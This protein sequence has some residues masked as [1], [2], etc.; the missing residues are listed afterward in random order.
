MINF[1]E[2][3]N[4]PETPES[5]RGR[6]YLKADKN[7]YIK[8]DTGAVTQV[9][10]GAT[11][12]DK[13][14]AGAQSVVSAVDFNN[15]IKVVDGYNGVGTPQIFLAS[16]ESSSIED[17]GTSLEVKKTLASGNGRLAIDDIGNFPSTLIEAE[18]SNYNVHSQ[19]Q[20][21]TVPSSNLAFN[22]IS[23][24]NSTTG[25]AT[26]SILVKS[27][28][29]SEPT[30]MNLTLTNT[31]GGGVDAFNFIG[32]P[33]NIEAASEAPT[34]TLGV[35]GSNEVVQFDNVDVN[36]DLSV[37]Q[38]IVKGGGGEVKLG[39]HYLS[40]ASSG[41][42]SGGILSVSG[43]VDANVNIATT[44][45]FVIDTATFGIDT[46]VTTP[47]SVTSPIVFTPTNIATQNV[48]YVG[49]NSSG[50]QVEWNTLPTPEQRRDNIFLGVAVHS[51]RTTVEFVNNLQDVSSD[52]T[53]QLHDLSRYLGYFNI[54]GNGV[55]AN[56]ANLNFNKALGTAFKTG[57]NFAV[58]PKDPDT[59]YLPAKVASSFR[60]RT[61]TGGEGST[62]TLIDPT[63]YDVGGT[64]TAIAGSNNQSTIQ[65]IYV[66][67]SNE[68]RI[69]YGQTLYS[70]FSDAI[71]AVG[72]EPFV[73]ESNI[74]ENGLLL[75][76]LVVK[77]GATDLSDT[78]DA[79][80][81]QAG[82][83]GE[84]GS[85][86][87]TAVGTL[88]SG[89]D[90]SI[91]PEILTNATL[92]AVTLKRGS[93]LDTDDVLEVQNGAGTQTFKVT[94][95]GDAVVTGQVL[96]GTVT[97]TG[98]GVICKTFKSEGDA[99]V[100]DNTTNGRIFAQCSSTSYSDLV[101]SNGTTADDTR[102]IKFSS[103]YLGGGGANAGRLAFFHNNAY[104]G[105]INSDGTW[106]FEEDV[107]INADLDVTGDTRS[108]SFTL[109]GL[110]TAPSSASD[111]GTTGEIRWDASY[112][113]VCTATNTW[114]RSAI[115]TW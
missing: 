34:K 62:I 40:M 30:Q 93:A 76:S 110:N 35:N 57:V 54:E 20:G 90:N 7:M 21:Y 103:G 58:N 105:Y 9:G 39:P 80:F 59:N 70:S 60:Y 44:E 88:Q 8:D 22:S 79:L 15:G 112:M 86:G 3:A 18:H 43:P 109:N 94:G 19:I 13:V 87:S 89:Y 115:A 42:Y 68:I 96:Q 91:N 98:E 29:S 85:V 64:I 69:Q 33:I 73:T 67:A 77:K 61:Q 101:L 66:F 28:N 46:I 25:N 31:A 97:D 81:F 37:G 113:Y 72:K 23:A 104:R 36:V 45:G 24:T 52:I 99:I 111:T 83:F 17:D 5:S 49:L 16:D 82:R 1:F 4:D 50:T 71:S 102:F 95:D 48:T 65:K 32:A 51:N 92:G 53:G 100:G 106:D 63:S 55:T 11:K 14:Q 27:G 38:G 108:N 107:T 26:G 74:H 114:K 41:V 10:D 6:L 47:V 2:R 12:L 75:C 84:T 56:G 78:A